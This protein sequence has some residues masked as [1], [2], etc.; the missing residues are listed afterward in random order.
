MITVYPIGTTIYNPEK[1]FGGYTLLNFLH[2][3][4]IPLFDMN[5]LQK[6]KVMD[7]AFFSD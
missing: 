7:T 3:P 1:A 6:I 2:E 5:M 4:E